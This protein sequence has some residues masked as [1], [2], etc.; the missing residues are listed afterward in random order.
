ML[1]QITVIVPFV[2]ALEKMQGYAKFMKDL[3]IKKK[4]V[5]FETVKVTHQCNAI[6]SLAGVKTMED[7]RAFIILYTI[8]MTSFAKVLYYL[9]ASI[10][11]MPY[12][13]FKRLGLG[14]P[15]PTSMKLLMADQTLKKP[16]RVIDDILV[17]EGRFYFS[18]D[19]VILDCEVDRELPIKLGRLYLATRWAICNV[20]PGELKFRLNDDE[21]IFYIQKSMKQSHAYGVISVIDIVDEVVDED[22]QE[23]CHDQSLRTVPLDSNNYSMDKLW[24]QSFEKASL[25]KRRKKYLYIGKSR[26][27]S[28]T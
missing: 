8:G 5:N 15:R 9:G 28:F 25:Y 18:A 10:N 7:L 24:F 20:E 19:F 23:M 12:T 2:E 21:E 1:N 16:L 13:V 4:N 3:V 27:K 26:R 6:I 17:N 22:M 11:L 14:D